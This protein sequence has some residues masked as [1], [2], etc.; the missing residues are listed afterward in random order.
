VRFLRVS[1]DAKK[2][3]DFSDVVDQ[4]R[5]PSILTS[6][7]VGNKPQVQT[8]SYEY[9]HISQI[10]SVCPREYVIGALTKSS[11]QEVTS[12]PL[13][14]VFNMGSA[15][16]WWIQ[17]H[18]EVY[19]G[20][21]KVLGYWYCAA[22]GNTRR[23]GTK[24]KDPCEFCRA[25]ARASFYQEYSFRLPEKG[26]AGSVDLILKVGSKYR[27]V[28]LK[29][30]AKTIESPVGDDVVQV[31]SYMHFQKFDKKGP[32]VKIDLS[33]GYLVYVN[34]VFNFKNP[35]STF[36]IEPTE[37]LMKPIIEKA[38]QFIHGKTTGTLPAPK[39]I[40]VKKNFYFSSSNAC[41]MVETCKRLFFEGAK[42]YG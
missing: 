2:G 21:D 36:K 23:F 26:V 24:P 8:K 31:S 40:C 22:C 20:E 30:T 38:F 18:P 5:D 1:P 17:N 19:F 39:E 42:T 29:S 27:V 28:D 10:D 15:L 41:N 32:P 33:V 35:V 12:F 37:R 25:N 3:S 4:F 6:H 9:I 34:K 13:R 14:I 7:I 16:H 11:R